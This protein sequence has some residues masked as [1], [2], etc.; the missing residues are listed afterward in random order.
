MKKS[1]VVGDQ[2]YCASFRAM[3]PE[4]NPRGQHMKRECSRISAP[5]G[6]VAAFWMISGS[7]CQPSANADLATSKEALL[8]SNCTQA[9]DGSISCTCDYFTYTSNPTQCCPGFQNPPGGPSCYTDPPCTPDRCDPGVL[10]NCMCEGPL[11]SDIAPL[12]YYLIAL[13]YLP[14]GNSSNATYLR[15]TSIGTQV[16]VQVTNAAGIVAQMTGPVFQLA[17]SFLGGPISGTAFQLVSNGS[18]GP[19]VTSNSDLIDHLNDE[20][21]LWL[22]PRTLATM[23]GN[24]YTVS[25]EPEDQSSSPLEVSVAELA[26]VV[27]LPAYKVALLANLSPLDKAGILR[28]DPFITGGS[29]IQGL[30][31]T[32]GV[33]LVTLTNTPALDP[34]R[35]TSLK[36]HYLVTGPDHPTDP[37]SGFALDTN[38]QDI[39]GLIEGEMA[40]DTS[41]LMFGGNV[42]FLVTG[43]SAF[44]GIQ[45][46]YT[47]QKTTQS[48]SGTVT[49]AQGQLYSKTLCWHQGVDLYWDV[50]FGTYLFW[51]TDPG[52]ND[53]NDPTGFSGLVA[54]LN[55][56][57]VGNAQVSGTAP[58]GTLWI[59]AADAQGVFKFNGLPPGTPAFPV[60]SPPGTQAS[61]LSGS[62]NV[63]AT[64]CSQYYWTCQGTTTDA[65]FMCGLPP[66]HSHFQLRR[67]DEVG[68]FAATPTTV[69]LTGSVSYVSELGYLPASTESR[70]TY[71]V[72]LIDDFSGQQT[73]GEP[74]TLGGTSNHCGCEPITCGLYSACQTTL[75]DGCGGTLECGACPGGTTC[76][77]GSCCPPG[78]ESDDQGGC[79][80]APPPRGCR[81]GTYFDANLCR[82]TSSNF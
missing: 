12:S 33:P 45:Y 69:N 80:C 31:P 46:Q 40:Q 25:I 41:S 2:W 22:S 9:A 79:V 66:A 4:I 27:S 68:A 81:K 7:A 63:G 78:Y 64:S 32:P 76:T 73:C 6:A 28:T 30:P 29:A 58:D 65:V 51:P 72:C 74:L 21:W 37:P 26:G 34:N 82:C 60:S 20:F 53:C 1:E 14:P 52:S 19:V 3:E 56:T 77:A 67:W 36:R 38:S 48:N 54:T 5:L 55:G 49:D 70:L 71:E 13:T 15:G 75:D 18:W 59:T 11:Y 50:M 39:H 57:P 24:N 62:V 10:V 47:Y 16:Q 8:A 61:I 17:G 35:F 43:A 42:S 23:Q 44:A